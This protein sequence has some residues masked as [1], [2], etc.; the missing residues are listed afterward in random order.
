MIVLVSSSAPERS[1]LAAL[2]QARRWLSI[3]CESIQ[4]L[5]RCLRRNAPRVALLRQRLPDGT[6]ADAMAALRA[7]AHG[8]ETRCIVLLSADTSSANEA[9][10]IEFGADCTFRD[11]IRP[12]VLLAYLDRWA[13]KTPERTAP[14]APIA[15]ST[16]KLLLAGASL[17][18]LRCSLK[19]GFTSVR[20]T[21]RETELAEML[22]RS[23]GEVVTYDMLYA[24]ILGRRF[25]GNTTNLRVLLGKLT[26]SVRRLDLDLAACIEVI[27]KV[28]YR[29]L[30]RQPARAKPGAAPRLGRAA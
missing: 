30:R 17:D 13:A 10:L 14:V 1:A 16:G 4:D 23:A 21:P 3:P 19:R 20:I 27:P 11:P 12:E 6:A 24:E 28:G 26:A 25:A 8:L 7:S 9:R 29:V 15:A 22:A 2:C 18:P 5:N